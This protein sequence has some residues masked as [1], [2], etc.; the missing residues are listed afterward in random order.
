M[1]VRLK[2]VQLH[3]IHRGAQYVRRS[4]KAKRNNFGRPNET[5]SNEID[6]FL[7]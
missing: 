5:I 3:F 2:S 1:G 4:W 6:F 7:N